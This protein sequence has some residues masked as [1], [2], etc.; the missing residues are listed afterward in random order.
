MNLGT[1]R[2]FNCKNEELPVICGFV[3]ISLKRDL[4]D[5]SGYS[6]MFNDS[7]VDSFDAQI[8]AAQEL[9]K[10]YSETVEGKMIGEHTDLT[11]QE[12]I[13]LTN[14]LEGYLKLAG[15]TI[16]MKP[17]DF[18]LVQ[19]RTKVR[20]RDVEG[21]LN[22]IRPVET[23]IKRYQTEL[24]E[25]GM[26]EAFAARFTQVGLSLAVDK[27][28]RYTMI[29]NRAAVVQKNITQLND[30]HKQMTEICSI[31]KILYKKNN[32]AKLNDY[33][34]SFLLKQVHRIFK[35]ADTTQVK[36]DNTAEE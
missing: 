11:L 14:H 9:V 6:P 26:T 29:S 10:P 13:V 20:T 22:Q 12:I 30:L 35:S 34:V 19:L 32:A 7:Y 1:P 5:F 2:N 36:T 18:G 23:N 31:G 21:V 25:K 33:T 15:K 8:T 3:S 17:A 4:P 28:K 16:P 27:N 24:S